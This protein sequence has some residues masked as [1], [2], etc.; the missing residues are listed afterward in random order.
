MSAMLWCTAIAHVVF[1]EGMS[2]MLPDLIPYRR[3]L[4]YFTGLLEVVAAIGILLPRYEK[5]T[6]W[7]LMIFFVCLLPAN[8]YAACVHVNLKEATFDGHGPRYLW[9]RIPL[10]ICFITWVYFSVVKPIADR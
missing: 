1:V 4:V 10:Q 8:I 5:L 9:Y 7:L 6:G 3:E 2:L